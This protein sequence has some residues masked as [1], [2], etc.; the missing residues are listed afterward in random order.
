VYDI[1][2]YAMKRDQA[3]R[4]AA[5][6]EVGGKL[7]AKD[8]RGHVLSCR[9]TYSPGEKLT[10]AESA[11]HEYMNKT[12]RRNNYPS[13]AMAHYWLGRLAERKN[14]RDTA[15]GEYETALKLE[16]KNRYAPK[17]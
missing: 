16:P 13:P 12:P 9:D 17:R 7:D 8:P 1:G 15:I 3:D 4:L 11:I 5:V 10:E 2:D 14:S 6:V